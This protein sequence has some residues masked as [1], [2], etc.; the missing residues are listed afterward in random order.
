MCSELTGDFPA[1]AA[2]H[3]QALALYRDLGHRVGQALAINSLGTVQMRT[4][5][6]PAAAAS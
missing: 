5:D 6:Y 2:S 1:A 3:Q 4:G